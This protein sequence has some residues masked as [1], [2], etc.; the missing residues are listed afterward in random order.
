[1]QH[2]EYNF[3]GISW[4]SS[5][6]EYPTRSYIYTL[7][8]DTNNDDHLIV[9]MPS[10]Y[11]NQSLISKDFNGFLIYICQEEKRIELDSQSYEYRRIK[12]SFILYLKDD[13][14][15]DIRV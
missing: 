14:T 13:G 11:I 5:V 3:D 4:L 12:N 1:M 10:Q 8:F 9:K 6:F 2:P 7:G 15:A